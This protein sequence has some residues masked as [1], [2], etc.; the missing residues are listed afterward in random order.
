MDIAAITAD[1]VDP[2]RQLLTFG[3]STEF[4]HKKWP[5]YVT[6][7]GFGPEHSDALIRMACDAQLSALDRE[8]IE[9]WAPLHAWRALGQL[10][11][12]AAIEPLLALFDPSTI[13]DDCIIEVPEVFG[14]IG[15]AAMAPLAAYLADRS[16]LEWSMVA[17]M[18]GVAAIVE[19]H[20]EYRDIGIEIV[21]KMLPQRRNESKVVIG[22]AVSRLVELRAVEAIDAIRAAFRR[23]AVESLFHGTLEVVEIELG[24]REPRPNKAS[25]DSRADGGRLGR[26]ADSH[27]EGDIRLLQKRQEVGRNDPCPCGSGKKYKKC[28]L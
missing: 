26:S 1:Y 28:C 18:S 8:A 21:A 9:V 19:R 7:F 16:H 17:A 6:R 5:D 12:E 25:R 27:W 3:E 20:P 4:N 11:A 13:D 2:V 22:A 15:P 14:M 23:G 24:L 10:R